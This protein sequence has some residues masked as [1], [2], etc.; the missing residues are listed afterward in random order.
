M[1]LTHQQQQWF[2]GDGGPALQWAMQFNESLGNF[3]DA[4]CL[5]PV[6][7]AH[8]GPDTRMAGAAGHELLQTLVSAEA[9]IRVPGNLVECGA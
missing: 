9:Q 6:A 5:L 8:F 2:D 3:Y 1:R 7:S 4:E